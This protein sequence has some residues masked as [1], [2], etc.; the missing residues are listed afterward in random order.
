MGNAKIVN[1]SDLSWDHWS[2]NERIGIDIKDP[3]RKLG[4]QLCGFRLE[5]LPPG[6]QSSQLHRHH[7]QE[8]L[9]LI[10]KG[11]GTLRHGAQGVPVKAG[12]FILYLAGDPDPHTF[13]NTGDEPLEFVATGNRSPYE[14]CEYPELGTVFVE[15]L[16]KTVPNEEVKGTREATEAWYKAGQEAK[17]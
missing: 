7:L 9:F 6:K 14:V 5:R 8:E 13:V 2:L 10:L 1:L 4:S 11:T 15:A 16:N 3:A 17:K 12:D